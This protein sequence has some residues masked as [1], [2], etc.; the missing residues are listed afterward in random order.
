MLMFFSTADSDFSLSLWN[1]WAWKHFPFHFQ[2]LNSSASSE[3]SLSCALSTHWKLHCEVWGAV[4]SLLIS[5]HAALTRR[6]VMCSRILLRKSAKM[7]GRLFHG[8]YCPPRH[9]PSH[10]GRK[11][12]KSNKKWGHSSRDVQCYHSEFKYLFHPRIS[13]F[14]YLTKHSAF[15]Q[16][17]DT[18]T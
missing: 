16:K 8:L 11:G 9:C 13:V 15:Q 14:K 18:K 5:C 4:C 6:K 7:S 2:W 1:P 17:H 12:G 3:S 10:S